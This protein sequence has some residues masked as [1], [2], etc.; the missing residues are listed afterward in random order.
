MKAFLLITT[1]LMTLGAGPVFSAG[2]K[3]QRSA[4]V[5]AYTSEAKPMTFEP[6][7]CPH[8][9]PMCGGLV[10]T[11]DG[12]LVRPNRNAQN[13][14]EQPVTRKLNMNAQRAAGVGIPATQFGGVLPAQ[15]MMPAPRY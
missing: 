10:Q 7:G 13:T 1:A 4:Q 2:Y 3:T 12:R 8:N 15:P 6:G 14:A 5:P 11:Q 9:Q